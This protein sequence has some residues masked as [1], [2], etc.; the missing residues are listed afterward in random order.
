[1]LLATGGG[2][3]LYAWRA[4]L[5]KGGGIFAPVSREGAMILNNLFLVTACGAVFLGTLYPLFLEGVT[6]EKIS[7]G[8]PFFNATFIP[9]MIPILAAT[10]IGPILAWKR[11]DILGAM[12]R[13]K[14]ALVLA[15]VAA[16]VAGFWLIGPEMFGLL[17]A[18]FAVWLLVGTV[19]VA[20]ERVNLAKPGRW[21]RAKGLPTAFWGMIAAHAGLAIA[22]LG[23]VGIEHGETEHIGMMRAGDTATLSGYHITFEGVRVVDG[24]NY[25]ALRGRLVIHE[26]TAAGGPGDLVTVLEPENRRFIVSGDTTTEAAI[27]SSFFGDLYGVIGNGDG[28][29]AWTVRVWNKPLTPWLWTGCIMMVLGGFVSLTDRRLRIGVPASRRKTAARPSPAGTGPVQPAPAE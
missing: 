8:P 7:V 6:G 9:L 29:G 24:P 14:V 26:E 4:P 25:Q 15:A 21:R 22:V 19:T 11:G 20:A 5:L 18:V 12:Q 27:R 3:A 28:E 10:A 17:G 13:L 2:L 23:M 16:V 1:M